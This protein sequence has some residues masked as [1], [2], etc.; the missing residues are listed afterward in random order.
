MVGSVLGI[1]FAA[2]C[3]AYRNEI[4]GFVAGIFN[5]EETLIRFYQ[6]THLPAQYQQ[7]D[8][9]IIIIAAVC[10]STLAGLIPAFRASRL[11]PASALRSE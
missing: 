10:G 6:F 2:L 7:N 5:K 3:L 4:V 9:V 11:K 1:L 8:F